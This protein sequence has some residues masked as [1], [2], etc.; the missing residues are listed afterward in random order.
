[1]STQQMVDH[2]RFFSYFLFSVVHLH[3]SCLDLYICVSHPSPAH[4]FLF[5]D[6]K[7]TVS[8]ATKLPP[9]L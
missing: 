4:S 6:S 9:D 1:M 5:L 2:V 7:P 3:A 8:S